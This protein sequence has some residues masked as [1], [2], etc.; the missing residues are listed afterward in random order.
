LI[1]SF[2]V[3]AFFK[4]ITSS[5]SSVSLNFVFVHTSSIDVKLNII[6]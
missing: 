6:F 2:S 1:S 5:N 3:I 4:I